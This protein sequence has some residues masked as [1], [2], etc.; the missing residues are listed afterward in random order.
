MNFDFSFVFLLKVGGIGLNF[1][2]LAALS[3]TM[4]TSDFGIFAAMFSAGML[5][6]LP[7]MIGLNFS[8]VR[9]TSEASQPEI[10]RIALARTGLFAL[11]RLL[12]AVFAI[13]A[14][15][16]FLAVLLN[17]DQNTALAGLA[18]LGLGLTYAFS[19]VLQSSARS[20]DGSSKAFLFREIVWRSSFFGIVAVNLLLPTPLSATQVISVATVFLIATIC[21][22]FSTSALRRSLPPDARAMAK[23]ELG[24]LWKTAPGF[25]LVSGLS[26]S[27]QHLII[28]LAALVLTTESTAHFFTSFKTVQ[29]LSLSALAVNFVLTPRLRN[30]RND[31]GSVD[32][33]L[34]STVCATCA[35]LNILF[36]GAGIAV[37]ILFG[38]MIL[39]VFGPQ[40]AG[41][42]LLLLV[43]SIAALF[44]AMTGPSGYVLLMFDRQKQFNIIAA[45]SMIL[46]SLCCL[47][48]GSVAGLMGFGWG[49]VIWILL[50]NASV[51]A[52]AYRSLSINA[53]FLKKPVPRTLLR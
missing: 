18:T 27:S 5:I 47:V 31:E 29:I 25:M 21:L 51:A 24:G 42:S 15:A 40:Y 39:S 22:Q 26:T 41:D 13:C 30:L 53:T 3:N 49:Y 37:F 9:Y 52:F 17:F 45:A 43:L 7:A 16:A 36:C 38:G 48:G 8:I 2:A 28:I 12:A 34:I 11:A 6:S 46:G 32:T 1:A 19:E 33:D 35:W 23:K 14:V 50:Q 4:S 10:N 20:F 44:N